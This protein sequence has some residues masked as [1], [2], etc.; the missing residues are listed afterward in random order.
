MRKL[1][2]TEISRMRDIALDS[3]NHIC[4]IH[5]PV[6]TQDSY[7]EQVKTWTDTNN[8]ECGFNPTNAVTTYRGQ[9]V[10]LDADAILRLPLTQSLDDK[11]EVTVNT[12]RYRVEGINIGSTVKLITLKRTVADE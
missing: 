2:T 8:V 12:V 6:I 10:T 7:G 3:F 4:S 9:V 11:S 1:S 5:V